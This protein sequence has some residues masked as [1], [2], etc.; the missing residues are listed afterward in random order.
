MKATSNKISPSSLSTKVAKKA[1]GDNKKA[2]QATPQ[3]AAPLA[4]NR[5]PSV[6]KPV[7]PSPFAPPSRRS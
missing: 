2:N 7:V 5:G 1:A 4:I 3:G 6:E